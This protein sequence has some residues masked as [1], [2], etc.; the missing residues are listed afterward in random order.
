MSKYTRRKLLYDLGI[1]SAS[2][3]GLGMQ[4]CCQCDPPSDLYVMLQGPWLLSTANDLYLR[5]ATTKLGSHLYSYFDPHPHPWPPAPDDDSKYGTPILQAAASIDLTRGDLLHFDVRPYCN[6]RWSGAQR[7]R[8]LDA[9]RDQ[10]QGLFYTSEVYCPDLFDRSLNPLEIH[11]SYPDAVFA[12]G[13][14]EGVKFS[15]LDY[16]EDKTVKQWP[17]TIVLHYRNWKTASFF[18][19]NICSETLVRGNVEIHRKLGISFQLQSPR[20]SDPLKQATNPMPSTS[21]T[22]KLVTE[23]TPTQCNAEQPLAIEADGYWASV[24]RLVK[25]KYEKIPKPI[26]P[27]CKDGEKPAPLETV[28]ESVI[29]QD[30]LKCLPPNPSPKAQGVKLVASA[31]RSAGVHCG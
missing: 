12:L 25:F 1:A 15:N 6:R 21:A 19:D 18:G 29:T 10:A 9:M 27:V 31:A 14:R 17:S 11:L 4:G 13:L 16:V 23:T 30:E 22:E 26:L 2:I 28:A 8:L 7:R 20:T 5:A 24:M 3:A